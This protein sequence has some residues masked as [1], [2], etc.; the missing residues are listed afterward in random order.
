VTPNVVPAPLYE[1]LAVQEEP[2]LIWLPE[3][4]MGYYP[5]R[6]DAPYNAAYFDKYRIYAA[7]PMGKLIREFRVRLVT[8]HAPAGSSLVDVGIGCGDFLQALAEAG[9]HGEGYDVNPAGIRWLLERGILADF[10][11]DDAAW[12]VVTFWDA[13][14][15]L[16]DP[17]AALTRARAW[18]FVTL[19]IFRDGEHVLHSKHYR[20]DEHLWYW[21]RSGFVRWAAAQGFKTWDHLTTESVL[22]R[23]DVETFVLRRRS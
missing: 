11:R 17:G 2:R 10:W 12:D 15:H 5:V 4:G 9:H 8:T 14:E 3:L 7:T 13:L 1:Y 23:E 19:P 20:K 6:G 18:A 16:P 22:G 21:T